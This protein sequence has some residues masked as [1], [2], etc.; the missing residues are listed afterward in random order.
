LADY[1]AELGEIERRH[2]ELAGV[3]HG[4]HLV[5]DLLGLGEPHLLDFAEVEGIDD[6]IGVLPA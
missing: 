6:Q 5:C 3:E 2:I 1:R 4:E